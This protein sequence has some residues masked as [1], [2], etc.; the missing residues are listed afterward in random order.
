MR[1]GATKTLWTM[2]EK[3]FILKHW[4]ETKNDT[5]LAEL[6]NT[7]FGKSRSVKSVAVYRSERLGLVRGESVPQ[8]IKRRSDER[9]REQRR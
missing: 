9:E 3:L 5:E 4:Q 6:I 2:Q 7:R 8:K 1:K